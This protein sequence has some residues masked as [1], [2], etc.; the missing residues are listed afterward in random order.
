MASYR[1]SI[2]SEILNKT[3]IHLTTSSIKYSDYN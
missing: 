1:L 2:Y 3:A